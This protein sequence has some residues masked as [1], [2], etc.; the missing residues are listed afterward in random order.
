MIAMIGDVIDTLRETTRA[1]S[2]KFVRKRL[3]RVAVKSHTQKL[4][5]MPIKSFKLRHFADQC[6]RSLYSKK[7]RK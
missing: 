3:R 5:D 6:L 7:R 1:V 4:F 2:Q